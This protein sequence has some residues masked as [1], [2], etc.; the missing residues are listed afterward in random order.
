MGGGGR[1]ERNSA[2]VSLTTVIDESSVNKQ[3]NKN[4]YPIGIDANYTH[5]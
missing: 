1:G 5:R 3:T 2:S 4:K